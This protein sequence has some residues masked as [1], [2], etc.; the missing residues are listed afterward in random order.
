L[1]FWDE[2]ERDREREREERERIK[3]KQGKQTKGPYHF[4][5]LYRCHRLLDKMLALSY[6][7][8][9]CLLTSCSL[10]WSSWSLKLMSTAY[11]P[12]LFHKLPW[13]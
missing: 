6:C 2:R 1:G 4:F 13:S 12:I 3:S 7:S 5:Y 11:K 8:S 10:P 9:S